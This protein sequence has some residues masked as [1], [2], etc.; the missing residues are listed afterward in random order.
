[1]EKSPFVDQTLRQVEALLAAHPALF[2]RQGAVVPCWRGADGTRRGPYYSLRYRQEGR[3]RSLYLGA[4]TARAA[5]VRRLLAELQRPRR[6]S[7]NYAR[8]RAAIQR[9]LRA[10]LPR[11][12]RDLQGAGLA[13]KGTEIRRLKS[14]RLPIP[15]LT[16]TPPSSPTS[17]SARS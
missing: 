11:W 5:A 12:R 4:S 2:A 17:A 13:W 6:Q 1:M 9:S 10:H 8:Q 14:L 15:T 3:Q 7:L 16:P